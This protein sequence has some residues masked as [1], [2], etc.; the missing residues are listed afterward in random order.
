MKHSLQLHVR[1]EKAFVFPDTLFFQVT[2]EKWHSVNVPGD[3]KKKSKR[4]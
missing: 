3:R 2:C 4:K 1:G